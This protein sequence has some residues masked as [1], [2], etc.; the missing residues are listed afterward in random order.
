MSKIEVEYPKRRSQHGVTCTR[1][2]EQQA[3]RRKIR[4]RVQTCANRFDGK[5]MYMLTEIKKVNL[6]LVLF[7]K[8]E[9]R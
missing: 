7:G 5:R 6:V 3:P 2:L 4:L 8:Q 1:N 9:G